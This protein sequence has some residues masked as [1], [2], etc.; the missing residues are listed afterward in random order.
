MGTPTSTTMD[1]AE[2][3]S[4]RGQDVVV[5]QDLQFER[6]L[7]DLSNSLV[8]TP[9][10]QVD[11][12]I[13]EWM[14]RVTE[15][16]GCEGAAVSQF[17]RDGNSGLLTHTWMA[18]GLPSM[19]ESLGNEDWPWVFQQ[20]KL[21]HTVAFRS[22]DDL[23]TE[24]QTDKETY[25]KLGVTSCL[26]V[27]LAYDG[28][29][30]GAFAVGTLRREHAWS[31]RIT[32]RIRL[33]GELLGSVLSRRRAD[34]Q[35]RESRERHTLAVDGAND[36]LWDWNLLTNVVYFSP[37]WKGMLGYEDHE[38]A[39]DFSAWEGLLHPDDRERASATLQAYLS[40]LTPTYELEHRLRHKDGSYRWI[41]ARGKAL[42]DADGRPYRM[43]GSH[44]DITE[45]KQA[46]DALRLA[47]SYNR[48]LIEASLDPLVTIGPDGRITDVNAATEAATGCS[49]KELI[50]SDFSEY[51][52]APEKAR[53]GYQKVFREAQ[54][55]D[56]PLEIRHR[57]GHVTSI[58]YNASVYR[59]EAGQVIGV[60]AA[61]RDV[62]ELARAYEEIK[63]LKDQ[64]EAENLYLREGLSSITGYGDIVGTSQAI[65]H[66]IV[67]AQ[68]VAATD[69]TVLILGE[70]G[71]G[72]ELLAHFI[73]GQS[74]RKGRPFIIANLAAM[75]AT[76]IE[77]ELFGREK[78][79]FTGALTR[80]IGRFEAANEG[81]IFLDEIGELPSEAQVKLLRV[82]QNGEFERL[83]SSRTT[84][85]NVRVIAAT[86]RDLSAAVRDGTFRRDLYYR[87]NVFPITVPP[88][89]ERQ[90]DIPGLV[91]AFIKEFEEKMGKPIDRVKRTSM[92]A[93]QAHSW[94]GNVRELRNVIER[95]MILAKGQELRVA[96]PESANT[97][98]GVTMQD[99][100]RRHIR[101]ILEMAG[102]R[103]RGKGGAAEL[104]GL[105]ASTLYSRMKKLGIGRELWT[106]APDSHAD[107]PARMPQGPKDKVSSPKDWLGAMDP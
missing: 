13:R 18:P 86:N 8:M 84:R 28:I 59:N 89:R 16:L 73:H 98:A 105:K 97:D 45:R 6:L 94:P 92:A 87:L 80:Q 47:N 99:V 53:A 96:L 42:R 5:P 12:E 71:T 66:V 22:V 46:V 72:K 76:L 70:T 52:T 40:G 88:L 14:R 11:G 1:K 74:P 100:E 95:S 23:P 91:W 107:I 78:G 50:G 25:R 83:G 64:L 101:H 34:E 26:S 75:P 10:N 85:V 38:V 32:Q 7:S 48:S 106:P 90:E 104:L 33:V 17:A 44:T 35:L 65:R 57:N 37:R 31:D 63:R 39:N 82:L 77:S 55:R 2:E 27:P 51:F 36:G 56:Y 69:S 15:F 62:T 67:Q 103:V 102:G 81:T 60:F 93:L 30:I 49:R 3:P 43:A 24:A 21:G 61:A 58:V 68:Q 20:L 19:P 79:A 9:L 41:L 54:V 29:T 4:V